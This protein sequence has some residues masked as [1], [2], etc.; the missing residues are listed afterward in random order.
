MGQRRPVRVV[1]FISEGTIEHGMLQ[2]LSFKRS[3]FSGVL[4]GGE[5]TVFMGESRLTRFMKE[6]EAVSQAAP[7]TAHEPAPAPEE[8]TASK[9]VENDEEEGA[10]AALP[11]WAPL[12]ESGVAFFQELGKLF[13][14]DG[15]PGAAAL[16][17]L[18]ETDTVTG[19][20]YIKIP[21][22]PKILETAVAALLPLLAALGKKDHVGA[23]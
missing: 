3:I 16:S 5:D 20:A 4:D 21:V 17:R 9:S 2:V 8:E 23:S 6:I 14:P 11:S 22:E 15:R 1:N 13:T 18:L 10:P 12:V 19:R 7:Q